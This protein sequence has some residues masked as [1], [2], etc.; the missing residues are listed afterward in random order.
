MLEFKF[1]IGKGLLV[2]FV[3]RRGYAVIIF[4]LS[5]SWLPQHVCKSSMTSMMRDVNVCNHSTR[6]SQVS[7]RFI[8][9]HGFENYYQITHNKPIHLGSRVDWVQSNSRGTPRSSRAWELCSSL[10]WWLYLFKLW[11][12]FLTTHFPLLFWVLF[13]TMIFNETLCFTTIQSRCMCLIF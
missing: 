2:L 6:E 12:I 8:R 3:I 11:L 7:I 4:P 13:S 9:N 10:L 5:L 1:L